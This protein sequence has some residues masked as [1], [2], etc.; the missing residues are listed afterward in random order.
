M[1]IE[2]IIKF[3]SPSWA[4]NRE[5]ARMKLEVSSAWNGTSK[6]RI[7]FDGYNPSKNDL[8]F[9]IFN[10]LDTLRTYCSDLDRNN[11]FAAGIINTKV[12]SIIGSGLK[13]KPVINDTKVKISEYSEQIE[14]EFNLWA[15]DKNECDGYGECN[16]FE[17][18]KL[19]LRTALVKGDVFVKFGYHKNNGCRHSFKVYLIS[20]ERVSNPNGQVDNENLHSGIKYDSVTGRAVGFYYSNGITSKK[21]TYQSFFSSSGRLQALHINFRKSINQARGIPDLTTVISLLKQLGDF[22][23]AY[24]QKAI[25]SAIL[26]VFVKTED[27]QGMQGLGAVQT[28][29]P[30][31]N[32]YKLGSGTIIQGTLDESVE[33]IESKTPNENF[34]PFVISIL[35]QIGIATEIPLELLI[36]HF[37]SSYSAAQ[38]A[39][40]E[41]WRYV[42]MM[43]ESVVKSLCAPVYEGWFEAAVIYNILPFEEFIQS[44]KLIKSYYLASEW[45]G[46]PQGHID[47]LKSN[48]ADALAE[49]RGWVSGS[50]NAAMRGQNW[51]KVNVK[52]KQEQDFLTKN[53]MIQNEESV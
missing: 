36:K 44:N 33:I 6:R 45:I 16:F 39:F 12:T 5:T 25:V 28:P 52:R 19:V 2:K 32:R 14:D 37:T 9:D 46:E 8:N 38:A 30:V 40:L 53:K 47:Q 22:T 21:W 26:S 17:I 1:N 7:E 29:S 24:L 34:D 42:R 20:P 10:E 48:K 43:R 15:S 18:Q 51:Q 31:A 11:A 35:R 23:D 41:F 50:T 4:L 27:G 13:M 49:D 3:I